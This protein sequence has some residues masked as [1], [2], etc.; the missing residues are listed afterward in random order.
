VST[1][2]LDIVTGLLPTVPKAIRE[3][4]DQAMITWWMNLRSEGGLRLTDHGY[5]I[6]HNVLDIESW[7]VDISTPKNALSKKVILA[8]DKKL[9]W[10][11]YIAVGKKK[12]VFFSSKE[13]MMA[14]LYGDLKAWLAVG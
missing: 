7:S 2:K 14:S 6:M 11:Y 1:R 12:V 4:V 3:T 8:M 13:A 9:D 5:K 10:P